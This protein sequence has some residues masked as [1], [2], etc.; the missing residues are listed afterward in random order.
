MTTK[1][2]FYALIEQ[3]RIER[4]RQARIEGLIGNVLFTVLGGSVLTTI[5]LWL[6]R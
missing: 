5:I 6:T 4:N 3:A 1:T 2:E